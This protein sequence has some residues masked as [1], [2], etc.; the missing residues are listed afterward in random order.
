MAQ[1]SEAIRVRGLVQGVGF[2]PTVWRLAERYGVGGWVTNDGDGVSILACGSVGALQA[3]VTALQRE[4]PPLSRIDAIERVAARAL[5]AGTPFRILESR[6]TTVHTGVVPDAATCADCVTEVFDPGARRYRYPF[7]NCTRCGPRL[8]IIEA[9]PYDRAATTMRGFTLCGQCEIEY[10][11]PRDRRF[12]AQPV[13]CE[14]C[15]PQLQL[16]DADGRDV[17]LAPLSRLD[18]IDAAATLLQRGRIIAIKGLG[19]FQ[20][21]CD[22]CDEAAVS[23]LRQ[24]KRRER[25]PFALMAR[26]LAVIRR[27]CPV[28]ASAAALLGSPAAPIVLL[29]RQ[30]P[31]D[32][33]AGGH[34]GR[35]GDGRLA[36]GLAPGLN[37]LGFMLPNTPLHHLLL[38]RMDTPLVLTSGNLSEEPQCI[39][40]D[41]ARRRLGGIADG[42]LLH[43]RDVARRVDDSV[44]RFVAGE[45]RLLRRARGYAPAPIR[46]GAGF[47]RAPPLLAM[48]GE[49]K[50]TFCLLRDG[51]AV[52]SHHIGDL[53]E[54][55]T[56]ADYRRAIEQYLQLF[57]H[58]PALIAVDLHPEYLSRKLG[59]E[60]A[61][62][63]ALEIVAVQHH[64]AHVAACMAENG[65]GLDAPAVLGVAL[66]GLGYGDDDALWGGEFL[67]ADYRQYRRL[68][69]FMPVAM[70]GGMRAIHEPWLNTYA[71]LTA[72]IGWEALAG[73]ATS[74]GEPLELV[75][76]LAAKPRGLLDA[77]IARGINSPRASS[78]GR[79]F[80]AVAAA[81]GVCRERALYE[82]Q[83]ATELEALID[84]RAL[85]C[86]SDELAYPFGTSRQHPAGPL[87]LTTAPMWRA[88]LADLHCSTPAPVIAAR[89]HKGLAIAVAAMAQR[90][91]RAHAVETVALCGGVFQ[92][93]VLLDQS[94]QRL[95]CGGSSVLTHRHVPAND[96][97]LSLGQAAVAAA[98]ALCRGPISR[99]STCV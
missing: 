8:S 28:S 99:K 51:A 97:G 95:R 14:R 54:A 87:C 94:I 72:T 85:E 49:L 64:H 47:E 12:H 83:A 42:F 10:H 52:L 35:D 65:V 84:R 41:E 4:A 17:E 57:E 20:L 36:A 1:S 96:G 43:D 86:E 6:A 7:T 26:D 32:G 19:G 79:L 56:Q 5:P 18:A 92:N 98:R 66:D 2:R 9:L 91:C 93:S 29:E 81:L 59:Q 77:M 48:G 75:R 68:G 70:P 62:R 3:F 63:G 23:R 78:C 34:C 44:T 67:L 90:L 73:A 58:R 25:K 74:D 71:Q 60:L 82:G 31:A 30:P 76:F 89:F 38:A 40:N 88:L 11:D 61:E 53:E 27:Y 39:G 37:T 22:A 80:D 50:S 69:S 24:Q 45:P 21:A 46:L 15:G 16:T 55:R 33:R 13:A